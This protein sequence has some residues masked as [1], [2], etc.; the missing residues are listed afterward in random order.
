[1]YDFNSILFLY[2]DFMNSKAVIWGASG[3]ASV[4]TDILRL[5]GTYEISGFIDSVNPKRTGEIFCKAPILGGQEVLENLKLRGIENLI[6]A[7]GDCQARQRLATLVLSQGL[8]LI[9]AIHPSAIIAS[10]VPIGAGT[11]VAAGT[12]INPGASIGENAIINTGATVDHDC[13]IDNGVHIGPGVHL[14][15]F[16]HVKQETWIGIGATISDRITI[17]P[18]SIIGAGAVVVQDIPPKVVA[19]GVPA[20]VIRNIENNDVENSIN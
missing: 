17:G 8:K 14:G 9:T 7:I 18:S 5:E 19:F 4:V 3:H 6:V 15:G 11:V 13:T 20:K 16:T 12:V 2:H 1:V 10:D